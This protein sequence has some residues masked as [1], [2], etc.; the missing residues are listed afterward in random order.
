MYSLQMSCGTLQM[1]RRAT[2]NIEMN[3]DMFML[4]AVLGAHCMP[5]A[6]RVI[7]FAFF[8]DE[9]RKVPV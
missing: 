1:V 4:F 7:V 6:F 2:W 3:V 9:N 5:V 8:L